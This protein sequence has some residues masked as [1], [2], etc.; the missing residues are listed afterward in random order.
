MVLGASPTQFS[1]PVV[2]DPYRSRGVSALRLVTQ[3]CLT[4]CD[5]MDCSLPGSSVHGG[6]SGRNIGVGPMEL[7]PPPGDLPNPGIKLRS[8][9][10]QVDSLPAEPSGKPN[11]TGA[12][13]LSLLQRIFLTQES[14][15]GLLPCRRILYQLSYQGSL[16][17]TL[18]LFKN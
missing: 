15:L 18:D 4:L 11:N 17:F 16:I 14:N 8:P 1:A 3:P 9:V 7:C 13:S 10:L 5:P 6:S 2:K 12:G